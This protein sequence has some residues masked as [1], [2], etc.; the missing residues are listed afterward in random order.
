ML[1]N[2]HTDFQ[3]GSYLADRTDLLKRKENL[4]LKT[5]PNNPALLGPH[6]DGKD[7]LALGYGFDLLSRSNAQII[8]F[9]QSVSLT[10]ADVGWTNPSQKTHDLNLLDIY[11][12]SRSGVSPQEWDNRAGKLFIH[13]PTEGKATDLLNVLAAD[14]EAKLTQALSSR[15]FQIADSQERLALLSMVYNGGLGVFGSLQTSKLLDALQTDNR[16][17]AWY[18]IRYGTN[19]ESKSNDP[20]KQGIAPGI[21]NRRYGEADLFHLYGTGC[22]APLLSSDRELSAVAGVMLLFDLTRCPIAEC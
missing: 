2:L 20:G 9:L 10:D 11:R 16:A 8:T 18:Q 21:A 22:S 7:S 6:F 5:S 4:A 19:G 3:F 13:L 17:E 15:G 12:Q 14:A 1:T